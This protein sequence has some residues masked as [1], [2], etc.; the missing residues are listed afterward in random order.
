[1]ARKASSAT[2]GAELVAREGRPSREPAT[3]AELLAVL[4]THPAELLF[5]R[6]SHALAASDT[7]AG[8][9][10]YVLSNLERGVL[11]LA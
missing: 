7:D 3:V 11:W 9:R 2:L 1:M 10:G 5:R 8:R 6:A 4:R